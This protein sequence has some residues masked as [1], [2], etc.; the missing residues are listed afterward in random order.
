MNLEFRYFVETFPFILSGMKMTIFF[1]VGGLALGFVLGAL[2]GM[3]RTSKN[4][5]IFSVATAYVE[6]VRGTPILV[7]AICIFY[8]MPQLLEI[9]FDKLTAGILAIG[10]N[11]GAYIAEVV[12]GAVEGVPKGQAEAGRSLGLNQ[13][14]T[15]YHIV[16]PQA[17]RRMI[18]PLGNQF[19]ISLKDTSL[20]TIIGAAEMTRQAQISVSTNFAYFEVYTLLAAMYLSLTIPITII[21]RIVERRLDVS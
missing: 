12:R 10:I 21:L 11:S 2:I 6:V 14:Q 20:F 9:N 18:P 16:W 17:F 5:Y 8:A 15:L 4:K 13:F 19:I 3:A 1:T 7:Q